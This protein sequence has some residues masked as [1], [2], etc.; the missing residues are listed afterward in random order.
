MKIKKITIFRAKNACSK[1]NVASG[2]LSNVET[3]CMFAAFDQWIET[4]AGLGNSEH[5]E[6]DVI[7]GPRDSRIP[8]LTNRWGTLFISHN[9]T[10]LIS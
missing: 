8:G 1:R 10:P 7:R 6:D 5:L 9:K 3:F 2:E 4:R